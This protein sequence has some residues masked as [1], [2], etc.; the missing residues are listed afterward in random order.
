MVVRSY[1]E[2]LQYL[3]KINT[4]S[5]R[6]KKGFQ[7]GMNVSERFNIETVTYGVKQASRTVFK[8]YEF[9]SASNW[10]NSASF[11]WAMER[12]RER[13]FQRDP[14]ILQCQLIYY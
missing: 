9:Y 13:N 2:E 12:G 6:I 10:T 11:A 1:N 4:Y 8:L 5:W 14:G 3:E 7:P